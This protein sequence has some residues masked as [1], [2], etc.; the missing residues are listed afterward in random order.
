MSFALSNKSVKAMHAEIGSEA[1]QSARTLQ[2]NK[3]IPRW[4]DVMIA[5]IGLIVVAPVIVVMTLA[6]AASSG[7]PVFFRQKR[8]GRGGRTFDLYKLRSMKPNAEGVQITSR[9]DKRITRLGRL[10]R[11]EEHTSEL[12]SHLN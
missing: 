3:G 4:A 12:Q 10:M 9:D 8:V 11:S 1:G 5:S 2:I 6:I 7:R